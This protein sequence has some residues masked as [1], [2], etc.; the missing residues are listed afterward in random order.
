VDIGFG[1]DG[2]H[3]DKTQVYAFGAAPDPAQSKFTGHAW[4]LKKGAPI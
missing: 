2:Y 1:M 4:T 3:T